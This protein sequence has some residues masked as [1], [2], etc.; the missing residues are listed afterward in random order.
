MNEVNQTA[1]AESSNKKKKGRL[2]RTIAISFG[3]LLV[4]LIILIIKDWNLEP[5]RPMVET[6]MTAALH[7]TVHIGS[8][9]MR[10]GVLKGVIIGDIVIKQHADT[11]PYVSLPDGNFLSCKEIAC[12]YDL[13]KLLKPKNERAIE[14]TKIVIVEPKINVAQYYKGKTTVMSIADLTGE[15][16]P[17]SHT[18]TATTE[19]PK[20]KPAP[21]EKPKQETTQKLKKPVP[22][23]MDMGVSTSS[24]PF[25]FMAREIGLKNAE[26]TFTDLTSKGQYDNRYMLQKVRFLLTDIST[27]PNHRMGV[28]INLGVR[29]TEVNHNGEVI[30]LDDG[31]PKKALTWNFKMPG[32]FSLWDTSGS[33][34]P[35][36]AFQP[37]MYDG[38]FHGWQVYDVVR[39]SWQQTLNKVVTH[40]D[41]ME[42]RLDSIEKTVDNLEKTL[43]SAQKNAE[44]LKQLGGTI[45]NIDEALAHV[46]NYKAKLKKQSV[47]ARKAINDSRNAMNISFLQDEFSFD[48]V[49]T[50]MKIQDQKVLFE[51]V[52]AKGDGYTGSGNGY[53]TFTGNIKF[54]ITMI[55]N[56]LS[57]SGDF[58]KALQNDNGDVAM[59]VLVTGHSSDPNVKLDTAGMEDRLLAVAKEKAGI[60]KIEKEYKEIL[61]KYGLQDMSSMNDLKGAASKRLNQEADKAKQKATAA[62]QAK[63]AEAEAA[64]AQAKA[65]MERKA[66]EERKRAE[67]EAKR[68]AAE[69]AKKNLGGGLG[70]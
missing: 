49:K 65:E 33:L 27:D 9:T 67:E 47:I 10:F 2:F 58:A 60:D 34:N 40:I 16:A 24:I 12:R 5:L 70:F 18:D 55:A 56:S 19:Q 43:Q 45:D 29:I 57:I 63:K 46:Q 13:S 64:A 28:D 17:A 15:P 4:L 48:S 36:G 8:N 35:T 37:E 1:S 68:K 42:K 69:E 41:A 3:V 50:K 66:E 44:K 30:I 61:E 6:Q 20:E 32:G 22:D 54:L 7:R 52:N 21:Q 51:D 25:S 62:A 53:I 14:I 23:K 39:N 31:Q 38:Y 11:K 26:I 59:N